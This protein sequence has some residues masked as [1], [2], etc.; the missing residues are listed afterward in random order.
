MNTQRRVTQLGQ[1]RQPSVY[2]SHGGLP[3]GE[4]CGI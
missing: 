4:S 1:C 3:L 2:G